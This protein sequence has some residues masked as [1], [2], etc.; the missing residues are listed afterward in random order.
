MS[1]VHDLH[2]LIIFMLWKVVMLF[3]DYVGWD[4]ASVI[5]LFL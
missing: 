3:D 1:F 5:F 2:V 4:F